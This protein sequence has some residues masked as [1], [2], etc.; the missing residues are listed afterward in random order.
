LVT[1]TL[2]SGDFAAGSG[3]DLSNYLLPATA[4]GLVGS[5]LPLT[6]TYRADPAV[7]FSGAPNPIFTGSVTGFLMGEN[8]ATATSGTLVFTST[9]TNGSDVG[10]YPINGSGLFAVNY[11]FV[12]ASENLTALTIQPNIVNQISTVG[13]QAQNPTPGVAAVPSTAPGTSTSP[14]AGSGSDAGTESSASGSSS[15][16]EGPTSEG[17]SEGVTSS[18]GSEDVPDGSDEGTDNEGSRTNDE[19]SS[20]VVTLEAEAAEPLPPSP[21]GD[22]PTPTPTDPED[23]SDPVLAAASTAENAQTT[24]EQ[25]SVAITPFISVSPQMPDAIRPV[26]QNGT[27]SINALLNP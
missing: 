1:A 19:P 14:N 25:V 13:S 27:L 22:E 7:R 8:I 23:A 20:Q 15:S 3:T 21:V 10:R 5:I 26:R 4:S 9:A 16:V 24:A 6:L 12:Q 11:V 2:G 18:V 17:A